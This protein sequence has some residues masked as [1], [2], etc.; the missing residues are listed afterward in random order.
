MSIYIPVIFVS[1]LYYAI[2]HFMNKEN[3]KILLAGYNFMT[4][5][6]RKKFD[7]E[8]YLVSF[9]TFFKN[10]AIYS[11]IIFQICYVLM[12]NKKSVILWSLYIIIALVYFLVKSNK[13][14]RID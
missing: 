2:G 8:N 5:E 4:D 9:K 11:F 7:I 13:I 10:Q 6:E 14:K 1:A 3:A 12:D